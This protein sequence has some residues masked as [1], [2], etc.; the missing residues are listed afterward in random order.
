MS[1]SLGTKQILHWVGLYLHQNSKISKNNK[2]SYLITR[3][4]S[5]EIQKCSLMLK[6]CLVFQNGGKLQ[7]RWF[8]TL[9]F[10]S[11]LISTFR[12]EGCLNFFCISSFK[13]SLFEHKSLL[14]H[15]DCTD[16]NFFFCYEKFLLSRKASF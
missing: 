9:P 1:T 15:Q 11:W 3:G 14:S 13:I 4:G 7:G 10:C 8:G 2:E 5:R 16:V 6:N 12:K